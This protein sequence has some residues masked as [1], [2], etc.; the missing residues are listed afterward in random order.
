MIATLVQQVAMAHSWIETIII[1]EIQELQETHLD[2]DQDLGGS[3]MLLIEVIE[4][5]QEVDFSQQLITQTQRFLKNQVEVQIDSVLFMMTLE[6][7]KTKR[8][9]QRW[10]LT[11]NKKKSNSFK[12]IKTPMKFLSKLYTEILQT[13]SWQFSRRLEASTLWMFSNKWTC[14]MMKLLEG[15]RLD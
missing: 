4:V 10:S 12:Q 11:E 2:Q 3:K 13:L 5:G 8:D 9:K 14:S 1:G 7:D 15:K 6:S